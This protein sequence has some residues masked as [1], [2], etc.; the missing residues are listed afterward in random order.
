MYTSLVSASASLHSHL[1]AALGT[2]VESAANLQQLAGQLRWQ[3]GDILWIDA[4]NQDHVVL[5]QLCRGQFGPVRVIV[6]TGMPDDSMAVSWLG[7]GAAAY[8][9]AY[10]SPDLLRQVLA[11][12]QSGGV[13][14][15]A[16][17]MQQLCSRFGQL[18]T[19]AAID[20][21]P[22]QITLREKEVIEQLRLGKSNKE[23]ARE[24]DITERT[25]KSH[26]TA[27]FTK[28]QVADRVQLL[29]KLSVAAKA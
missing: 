27:I 24:L 22:A 29:L 12:V 16:G 14:V 26:L 28:L 7:A 17:L 25:V 15:G 9:H 3:A 4:D 11:V 8:V 6:M 1:S 2:F 10:S 5:A 20:A 19:P 13:W 21:L 18:T 23:I